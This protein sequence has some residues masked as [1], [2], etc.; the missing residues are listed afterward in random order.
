MEA[1]VYVKFILALGFVVALLLIFAF[2]AK[3]YGFIANVTL[4]SKKA[5]D[6]RLNVVEILPID[7]KRRALILRKDDR[8]YLIL[9]GA[10]R[11][12]LIDSNLEIPISEREEA[13][14]RKEE[15]SKRR[16]EPFINV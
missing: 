13:S 8:E 4:K 6:R 12:L 16:K 7:T 15:N 14:E 10:E 5:K 3:K 11:D 1:A 2:L 9:L